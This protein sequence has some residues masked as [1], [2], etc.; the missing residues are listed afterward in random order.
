MSKKGIFWGFI[1][2][3]VLWVTLTVL[4]NFLK[5]ADGA[6]A[7]LFTL[8]PVLAGVVAAKTS[9]QNPLIDALV[10][11]VCIGVGI[12]ILGSPFSGVDILSIFYS[13]GVIALSFAVGAIVWWVASLL[14]KPGS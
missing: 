13:G 2:Y 8:C 14:T 9:T 6:I 7:A 3:S 1:S 10:C 12:S 4:I 5:F 11:G